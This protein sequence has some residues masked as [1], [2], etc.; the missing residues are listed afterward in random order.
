[1]DIKSMLSSTIAEHEKWGGRLEQAIRTN[2]VEFD[3][4][5]KIMH[6]FSFFNDWLINGIDEG[7]KVE[8]DYLRVV[9]LHSEFVHEV[10]S[11]L[12]DAENDY[13]EMAYVRLQENSKFKMLSEKLSIA[14]KKWQASL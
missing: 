10:T 6:N 9:W 14:L 4:R 5:N 12:E 11:I 7:N 2:S 8:Q 1:M 3:L 13:T